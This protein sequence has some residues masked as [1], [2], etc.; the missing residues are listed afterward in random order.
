MKGGARGIGLRFEGLAAEPADPALVVG[1]ELA[2]AVD[3]G[4][5]KDDG[6][7]AEAARVV[8]H[9]LVGGALGAAVGRVELD[10]GG[11][12]D[13]ALMRARLVA[14]LGFDEVEVFE[15][16]V[17]LVG[18]GVDDGGVAACTARTA[19]RTLME[20]S[21][22]ISK[23]RRGLCMVVVMATWPARW[24]MTSG[25]TLPDDRFDVEGVADV[26]VDEVHWVA[27]G[28]RERAQPC[29][30]L[31]RTVARQIVEDGDVVVFGVLLQQ[32]RRQVGADEA[33]ASG[34]QCIHRC[35]SRASRCSS[36]WNLRS[37]RSVV[38]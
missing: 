24:K 2:A 31:G 15:I 23:S 38:R 7:Q 28:R 26:A 35:L 20:P 1:G 25:L 4:V 3:G 5:A 10:G 18:G 9:V 33:A 34:D 13:A 11:F 19:S 6:V 30:I 32:V 22:L 17:D 21:T 8:E 16:A 12:V 37:F 27:F 14:R 36:F 29:Q